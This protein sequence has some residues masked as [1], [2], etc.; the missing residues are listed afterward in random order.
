MVVDA[1]Q[2]IA[3]A[4][5][6]PV[7]FAERGERAVERQDIEAVFRELQVA[8]DLGAQQGHDVREDAEAEAREQLLGDGRAAQ[9]LALFE[10]ESLQSGASE[11]C[12]A[13]QA[14]VAAADDDRV[15]ALRHPPPFPI[16]SAYVSCSVPER[17][18]PALG[19]T[20]WL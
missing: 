20:R 15:V 11:V 3:A 8:N 9:D 18:V 1:P 13:D 2:E 6:R 7:A 5:F 17:R 4:L 10:D 14:V 16:Q 19:H 12:R